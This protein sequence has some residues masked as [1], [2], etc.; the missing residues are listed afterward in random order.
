MKRGTWEHQGPCAAHVL[1]M[2]DK[3]YSMTF[4]QLRLNIPCS[5]TQRQWVSNQVVEMA[6]EKMRPLAKGTEEPVFDA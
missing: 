1:F 5:S 2:V 6:A 4:N 3:I